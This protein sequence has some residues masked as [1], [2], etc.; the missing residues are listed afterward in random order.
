MLTYVCRN[1]K[2]SLVNM[3][4]TF[5][6][7]LECSFLTATT[8]FLYFHFSTTV[9]V[10]RPE[11]WQITKVRINK[12]FDQRIRKATK[13]LWR[14]S[15]VLI[16]FLKFLFMFVSLPLQ[17]MHLSYDKNDVTNLLSCDITPIYFSVR[18]YSKPEI[19][20]PPPT[21][22]ALVPLENRSPYKVLK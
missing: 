6:G 15:S 3:L 18:T 8:L 7:K 13:R 20:F 17:T 19:A 12:C 5:C 1:N 21:S 16:W 22:L 4:V 9:T 14:P 10:P 2:A 11:T